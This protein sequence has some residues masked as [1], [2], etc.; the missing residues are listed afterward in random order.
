M[1]GNTSGDMTG[2]ADSKMNERDEIEALL[3]WHAA[4]TLSRRDARRVDDALARDPELARRYSLVREEL[5][6]TIGLNESLGVPS[7]RAFDKLMRGI[8]AEPAR[9]PRPSLNLGARFSEFMAGFSPRAVAWSAA[10]AILV[11]ALQAAVI[12]GVVINDNKSGGYQTASAPATAPAE[13]SFVMIRFAAQA[14]AAD[15]TTFLE[16]NKLAVV[17]GPAPGGLYRV[18]VGTASLPKTDLDRIVKALQQDKTVD[19]IATVH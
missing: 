14:S 11:I 18:R 4:G 9:R 5:G 19:F 12:T 13:G 15:I 17:G 8:D 6:E 1:T 16:T 2:D 10:A 3:P 7:A